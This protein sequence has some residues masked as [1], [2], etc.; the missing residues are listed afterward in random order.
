MRFYPV[1]GMNHCDGGPA[2]DLFDLFGALTAWVEDGTPPDA[3]T[4][5]A[6]PD[7]AEVP[8][9]LAGAQRL[10]CPWP[11]VATYRTGDPASAASFACSD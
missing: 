9:A 10:L 8:A 7:N 4:V 5:A 2:P 3:V 1:P 11:A 6:R